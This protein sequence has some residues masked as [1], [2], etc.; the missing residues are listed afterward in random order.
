MVG[1]SF[2]TLASRAPSAQ[3]VPITLLTAQIEV[4][5]GWQG[6]LPSSALTVIT[7]M[8]DASLEGVPLLSDRQPD[9]IR[10]DDHASEP[11]HIWLH[12][13]NNTRLA[14]IVVDVEERDWSRLAYQFG[15][16]LGHVL[17]NSWARNAKTGPPT[18]WLEESIVE[19]FSIR[20]LGH[21]AARW[22][23]APLFPGDNAYGAAV[24]DY[25]E[26]LI[27]KYTKATDGTSGNLADWLRD[28]R[29]ALERP[30]IGLNPIEGP[31]ILAILAELEG[32]ADAVADIGALNRWP[33]RAGLPL[34][35][36]FAKWVKSCEELHASGRLPQRLNALF[37]LG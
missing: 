29:P 23:T 15:H 35:Q 14:W 4:T 32:G 33:E 7:G 3:I 31:A 25:R 26:K 9:S 21:L 11:P 27:Q 1:T 6:S 37:R 22:E 24:R 13:D 12:F 20:G 36:Y 2:I 16:E 34:E 28:T 19:A 17:A 8:R 10:V 5:G 18:Q 30:A